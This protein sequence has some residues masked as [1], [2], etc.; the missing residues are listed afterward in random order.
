MCPPA[1]N[2]AH[3]RPG[4]RIAEI[5]DQFHHVLR[6][7]VR[8]AKPAPQGPHRRLVRA[9]R[10]SD[11][12]IDPARKQLGQGA[13]GFGHHQGGVV[14]QHDPARSHANCPGSGSDMADQHRRRCAGDARHVVMLGQPEPGKAKRL[15]TLRQRQR[16]AQRRRRGLSFRHRRQIKDGIGDHRAVLRMLTLD[17]GTDRAKPSRGC[18]MSC[19]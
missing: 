1:G 13:K 15:G 8:P 9:R 17:M 10:A 11:T 6:K 18:V 2:G 16:I 3:A 14:G 12:Q 5:P 4:L 7:T 19:G